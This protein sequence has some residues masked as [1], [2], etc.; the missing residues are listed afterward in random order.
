MLN[1]KNESGTSNLMV[2]RSVE[3]GPNPRIPVGQ[4]IPN[5]PRTPN[6]IWVLNG[7]LPFQCFPLSFF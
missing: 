2:M 5:F 3:P 7:T 1:G 4:A 6:D